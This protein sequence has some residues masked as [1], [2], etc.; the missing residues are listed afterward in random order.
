MVEMGK[1][2]KTLNPFWKVEE[3]YEDSQ[4]AKEIVIS[5]TQQRMDELT[6]LEHYRNIEQKCIDIMES[7]LAYYSHKEPGDIKLD[8]F[9]ARMVETFIKTTQNARDELL[10]RYEIENNLAQGDKTPRIQVEFIDA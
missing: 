5:Y 6:R 4:K 10:R 2:S 9:K 7:L 8:T 3:I 1:R